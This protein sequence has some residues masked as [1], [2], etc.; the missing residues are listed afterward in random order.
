MLVISYLFR[1]PYNSSYNPNQSPIIVPPLLIDCWAT[2]LEARISVAAFSLNSAFVHFAV[3]ILKLTHFFQA[4]LQI[5]RLSAPFDMRHPKNEL[6]VAF[7]VVFVAMPN[8]R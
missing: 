6:P 5:R 7:F 2:I 3:V 1:I 8:C 4:S